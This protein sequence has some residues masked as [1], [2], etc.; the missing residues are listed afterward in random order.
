VWVG[1]FIAASGDS[2]SFIDLVLNFIAPNGLYR[3][4]DGGTTPESVTLS[5]EY[6]PVDASDVP[7]GSAVTRSFT[8]D[9]S[10]VRRSRIGATFR[11]S[12]DSTRLS[13]RV[14]RTSNTSH[15]ANIQIADEVLWDEMY[16]LTDA[17]LDIDFGSVTL[18]HVRSVSTPLATNIRE[19]KL[20]MLATRMIAERQPDGTF[21]LNRPTR[22]A[23]DI[24]YAVSL[25]PMI[26]RLT[27]ADLDVAQIYET[28]EDARTY[29]GNDALV[30]FSHTFDTANFTYEQTASAIAQTLFCTPY[31]RG[32]S[33]FWAFERRTDDSALLF[34]HR[35]KIPGT[36]RRTYTFG[37]AEERDGVELEYTSPDTD[38]R[39]TFFVPEDRSA[40]NPKKI[41]SLGIRTDEQA[42]VHAYRVFNQIRY[43]NIAT[44]FESTDEARLLVQRER[45]LCADN[46]R[47]DTQDGEIK[48]QTGLVLETSQPVVF[49]AGVNYTIHLQQPNRTI[50]SI[51]ITAGQDSTHVLLS[52]APANSLVTDSG[53]YI[54]TTYVI[55]SDA[56]EDNT[57]FI[58]DTT[59]PR[60]RNTAV[61]LVNYDARYYQNDQDM[62]TP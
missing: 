18:A 51:A 17:G 12:T 22:N 32:Q 52:R 5:I 16:A 9:G 24:F 11:I 37:N 45:V 1:P 47:P 30:E 54:R 44:E 59:R 2:T 49:E 57:P 15:D 8:F 38:A 43:Q 48:L 46:T 58:L 60:G 42:H 50:D 7:T 21:L 31:R 10:A 20:N 62:A 26:G 33:V 29:F 55:T 39:E 56:R 27:E 14:Q 34:N 61:T 41:T 19:R 35:N 40:V 28:M 25:D 23:A 13:V 3:R 36:E 4:D 53:K 6:T